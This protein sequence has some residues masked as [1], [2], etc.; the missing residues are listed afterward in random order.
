VNG[1]VAG[2]DMMRQTHLNNSKPHCIEQRVHYVRDVGCG[3]WGVGVGG[4]VWG[5][6]ED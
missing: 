5:D 2:V 3:V 1:Q 4:W 6:R